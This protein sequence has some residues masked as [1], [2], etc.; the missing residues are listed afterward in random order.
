MND[1]N[2]QAPGRNPYAPPAAPVADAPRTDE[3]GKRPLP[4]VLAVGALGLY[5]LMSVLNV[6]LSWPPTFGPSVTLIALLAAVVLFLS[7][8]LWVVYKVALGENWARVITLLCAITEVVFLLR[9]SPSLWAAR[10]LQLA[11]DFESVPIVIAV[12]LLFLTPGRQW[13]RRGAGE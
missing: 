13:F 3:R 4:V 10:S 5:V 1:E 7:G 11:L 6:A 12:A 9:A 8:A 2:P